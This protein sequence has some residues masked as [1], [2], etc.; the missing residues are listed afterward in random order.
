MTVLERSKRNSSEGKLV[1]R[2]SRAGQKPTPTYLESTLRTL[3]VW[4]IAY[5]ALRLND[6][7]SLSVDALISPTVYYDKY[8]SIENEYKTMKGGGGR[9]FGR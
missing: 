7:Y 9:K 6:F 3:N 2:H 4:F 8:P 1:N 5:S